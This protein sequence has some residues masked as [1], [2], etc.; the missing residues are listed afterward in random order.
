MS[1]NNGMIQSVEC[2]K[3]KEK[4][5]VSKENTVF[6]K[7]YKGK[8]GQTIFITYF[9][10]PKCQERHYVQIDNNSTLDI[11]KETMKMFAVVSAKKLAG[12]SIPKQQLSK[13]E[14]LRKKLSDRRFEL[15]NQYNDAIVTDTETGADVAIHFTV[16]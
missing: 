11:K 10:C 16:M 4:F 12:K 2:F 15:M 14:K 3:C 7:Q 9:D 8:N 13:F 1:D 6:E 5:T